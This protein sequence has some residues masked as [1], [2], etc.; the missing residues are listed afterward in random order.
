M[1]YTDKNIVI[2][3]G[4]PT[5][6]SGGKSDNL[7]LRVARNHAPGDNDS[8]LSIKFDAMISHDITYVSI[9][10]TARACGLKR[11][12]TPYVLT[13]C[14]NSLCA[15]G[16][17]INEDDHRFGLSAA[18]KY[19]GV[20]VPP[21]LAVIHQYARE[22]LAKPRM[23]ILGS[24]SHT[25]FGA[26][27][28]V[29]IG[30]G[31]GELVKQLLEKPYEISKPEVVLVWLTGKLK[32]GVGAMDA[33]LALCAL[34]YDKGLAKNKVLEF[35]GPGVSD[36]TMD[37]RVALDVMTT[38]TACLSSIWTTDEA[39]YAKLAEYG[40]ADDYAEL[41][42][43]DGMSYD[44]MIEI[45]LSS[46]EPMIAL[47][48]H[49]SSAVPIREFLADTEKFVKRVEDAAAKLIEGTPPSLRGH[50]KPDGFYVDQGIIAGC[51]GGIAQNIEQ[52][53]RILHG[54]GEGK[55][56]CAFSGLRLASSPA[57]IGDGEFS[58]SVYPASM[59]LQLQL[60]ESGALTSLAEAG[61][62]I[63]PCFCG[64]CF[65]AGDTPANG[66]F[67]IRHTTRNFPSREGSKPGDGQLS[68]VALM[69]VKSIAATALNHGR[70]TPA[71]ALPAESGEFAS[72]N[73]S[74]NPKPYSRVYDG[75]GKPNADEPLIYGPNI[76]DWPPMAEL[77]ETA[78][79]TLA[80]VIHDEVTTTDEL[81]P[82][83]E[84]SSYRSNP[85]KLARFTLSRR[86]PDYVKI[87]DEVRRSGGATCVYANRPGDGSARE[88]AA[89]CQRVLGTTANI[90]HEYATKRYRSNLI[91]W[92]IVPFT[93][94]KDAAFKLQPRDRIIVRG[95][96]SGIIAGQREFQ[97][98]TESADGTRGTLALSLAGLSEAE[99]ELLLAGGLI[100]AMKIK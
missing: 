29:G 79:L 11:F 88:Q 80:A 64:P 94:T 78:E 55:N 6:G 77:P 26:F 15:V 35:A 92:G 32:H 30:E 28:C 85:M 1:K 57:G 13:N 76:A 58:L 98:E 40:R 61:A 56:A 72:R 12:P 43:E 62:T 99:K 89:S 50:I 47:P 17:T 63:K 84:T 74:W 5:L 34:V 52:A 9:L 44:A 95:L 68:Y 2:T 66:A 96:R 42:I 22:R 18:K 87:A 73:G 3:D 27:G 69:D 37:E 16:G 31:G 4:K 86:V 70:L 54:A 7:F 100:N 41:L 19:G 51:A 93:T 45:D 67:S 20:F 59:P 48:F 49:P 14:H 23:M 90:A 81:I 65:G 75:Y 53:A 10:Q 91:N 21:N 38:E 60:T 39:T 82:S 25:R 36:M 46:I 97:A 33:A 71:D 8:L 83:G 24:D